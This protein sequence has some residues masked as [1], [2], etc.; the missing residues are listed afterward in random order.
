MIYVATTARHF[1]VSKCFIVVSSLLRHL[2]SQN[3][4]SQIETGTVS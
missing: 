4:A 2:F 3:N 1:H